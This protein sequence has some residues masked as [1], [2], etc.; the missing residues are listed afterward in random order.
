MNKLTPDKI[1]TALKDANHAYEDRDK[2]CVAYA[3]VCE[4]LDSLELKGE[5]KQIKRL[6]E[7]LEDLKETPYS[8]DNV[9]R[10]LEAI[11]EDVYDE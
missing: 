1:H 4:I 11:S 5:G 6:Y 8:L 7:C 10:E 9:N 3:Q 2:R